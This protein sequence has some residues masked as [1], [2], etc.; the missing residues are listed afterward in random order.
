MD[1]H[2]HAA[3]RRVEHHPVLPAVFGAKL[4]AVDHRV[5]CLEPFR[6]AAQTLTNGPNSANEAIFAASGWREPTVSTLAALR[7]NS[8]PFSVSPG[9]SCSCR[10]SRSRAGPRGRAPLSS[11]VASRPSFRL[12]ARRWPSRCSCSISPLIRSAASCAWSP[13]IGASTGASTDTGSWHRAAAAA[14]NPA[15]GAQPQSTAST[16]VGSVP[17]RCARPPTTT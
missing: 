7:L 4:Y 10:R 9:R 12:A 15:S 6:H 2:K 8:L 1:L 16:C 14:S 11:L 17:S 3:N 13:P 5:P